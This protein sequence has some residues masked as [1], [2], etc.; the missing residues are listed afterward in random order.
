MKN[1]S[2]MD[3]CEMI[4]KKNKG[5]W[6]SAKYISCQCK[7]NYSRVLKA[8]EGL[9]KRELAEKRNEKFRISDLSRITYRWIKS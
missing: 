7:L 3:L 6:I 4:L 1:V 5:K 2:A 9:I 8:C